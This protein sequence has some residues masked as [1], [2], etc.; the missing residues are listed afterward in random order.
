ML[1]S[2]R[3]QFLCAAGAAALVTAV[4][5]GHFGRAFAADEP[6]GPFTLPPLPYEPAALEPHIDA[7]TMEL[8][9]GKHH[10]GYVTKLNKA[11][12]KQPD[13][14]NL[15][16]DEL[17]TKIKDVPVAARMAVRNNA[18]GH[19]N[20]SMFWQIMGAPGG[21]GPE[22]EL[23][24]AIDRD[25]GGLDKL[26]KSFNAAGGR[27]FGSGWVFITVEPDGKLAMVS[28]SNQ[29]TP[30]MDGKRVLMGNDVWEHAYYLKYQNK[31]ADYL[32]AWWNVVNWKV[33]GERYAAAKA[34]TLKI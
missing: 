19:A 23:L 25:F 24:A 32:D 20:H 10:A 11:L 28:K 4:S 3:R 7:A 15:P 13:F 30:L 12:A 29:N 16:L 5:T 9:H 21:P 1:T 33:V 6:T 17:L 27:L 22:G 14:A 34:G 31:R 26:K 8:H 18:G 2:D